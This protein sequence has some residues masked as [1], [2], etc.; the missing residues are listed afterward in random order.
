MDKLTRLEKFKREL[1]KEKAAKKDRYPSF[2]QSEIRDSGP[3][4]DKSSSSGPRI[5]SLGAY[6]NSL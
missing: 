3:R 4:G 2:I 5:S 6:L 1:E